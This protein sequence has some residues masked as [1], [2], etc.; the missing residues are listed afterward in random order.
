MTKP[1][2][3]FSKLS[4]QQKIEWLAENYLSK[5]PEAVAILQ[6]YWNTDESLQKLH[7]EFIENTISNYYLP[8]GIAPNFEI[9]DRLYAIP[10]A[11]EESSVVAAASKAAKFWGERGGFKAEVINMTKI[12]QVHFMFKG[13][14]EHLH[15]F[16]EENRQKMIDAVAPITRNMEKRGG[17]ILDLELIDKTSD[18]D[19][20]YQLFVKF[21]TRDSMGANFIN[22]C[23]EKF[24]EVLRKQARETDYFS[25]EEKQL[26]IV[27]SILS[28][29]VPECIV[30]AE[31]S[32]PVDQLSDIPEIQGEDFAEKFIQAIKIAEIEPYRAVTHNKGIMNG[33][34]AVVLA[35]G[36][37][38][39]AV[40]A[41][42]HAYASR[43]GKYT[44]LTHAKVEDGIF[45]FW[46][47]IPLALGTVG[48][49][50]SLHPLVK[51]ALNML[52][53]PSAEELMKITA[54]AGLAQNFA[55]V[56]SLTTTG[57]Q[58]GHM[59]MHLMNILNQQQATEDEKQQMIKYFT[60]NTITHSG[61]IEQLERIRS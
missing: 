23:L 29:Y 51:L 49:L 19:N 34:D 8:F 55:A 13:R 2:N 37:D 44:S 17:G 48:G 47:E 14:K 58:Q 42:I 27:M 53:D 33:I 50:T 41:G 15:Q 38:F 59:K 35:T 57:I 31:V 11:I 7:D 18:L 61:V 30:R 24:A 3:G 40:E 9:N 43:N 52:Q 32:C 28:N 60:K 25:E 46:M 54:V 36:N 26:E 12:G 10:M 22:S 20:Y 39:R 6:N 5:T 16:F 21:D 1:V 45:H 4:K 56:K